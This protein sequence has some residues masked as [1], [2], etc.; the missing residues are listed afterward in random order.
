MVMTAQ[1]F[2]QEDDVQQAQGLSGRQAPRQPIVAGATVRDESARPIDAKVLDMSATGCLIVVDGVIAVPSNI[3]IGIAGIGR[4]SAQIVRRNGSRYGCAF[5]ERL[6]DS[7][8]LAAR[9]VE[10][11]VPF[12]TSAEPLPTGADMTEA[13]PEFQ[14]LPL[15]TRALVIVGASLA[16]WGVVVTGVVAAA[17]ALS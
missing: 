5:D 10:T 9:A 7:A 13:L 3:S 15:R 1:L 6:S 16:L 17:A 4:V 11:V 2:L 8:I 12:A 14:R